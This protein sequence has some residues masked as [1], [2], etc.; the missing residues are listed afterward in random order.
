M[1]IYYRLLFTALLAAGCQSVQ[2]YNQ[3]NETKIS[4]SKLHQ[5]IKYLQKK[6]VAMHPDTD[7]Y[8]SADSLNLLFEQAKANI[9]EPLT[10]KDFY[11]QIAPVIAAVKQG[12]SRVVYPSEK[13]TKEQTEKYKNTRGPFSQ[14]NYE[15]IQDTL[16]IAG[17]NKINDNTPVGSRV[18][19]INGIKPIELY[20]EYIKNNTSDGYNTTYLEK[21]FNKRF[22]T[23]FTDKFGTLDSIPFVLQCQDSLFTVINKRYKTEKEKKDTLVK[24]SSDTLTK[25][26]KSEKKL[27]QKANKLKF[28]KEKRLNQILGSVNGN[29]NRELLF[30]IVTD[31]SYAVLKIRSFNSGKYKKAYDSLFQTIKDKK[32]NHLVLDLRDNPGGLIADIDELYS[33]LKTEQEPLI[34]ESKITSR[35]KL[36]FR[37]IKGR[38]TWNYVALAPFFPIYYTAVYLNTKK[39][40]TGNYQFKISGLKAKKIQNNAYTGKLDVL[41]NGGSFS[42]SCIITSNLQGSKQATIYGEE[43]GGTFNGTVAG[44][45]PLLKLP[46]SKLR[47]RTGLMHIKPKYQTKTFGH[48]IFPDILINLTTDEQL[49]K[50]NSEYNKIYENSLAK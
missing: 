47:V 16:Y 4:V 36:P 33:Y 1:K 43:T 26:S 25:L 46:N 7:L 34:R 11:N 21:G 44:I 12:H 39:D 9:T 41:V 5:D 35:S 8:I 22:T 15:W 30:P 50:K 18:V 38:P 6:F 14:F 28:E 2:K 42:A 45:M 10:P 20:Q 3:F 19:K 24:N 32:I 17:N 31:S 27:S 48:G 40:T 37:L 49:F 23:L 29:L 13:K